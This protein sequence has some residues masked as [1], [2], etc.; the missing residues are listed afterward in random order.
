[1]PT[2]E[3][4]LHPPEWEAGHRDI[5]LLNTSKDLPDPP[6]FLDQEMMKILQPSFHDPELSQASEISH[7]VQLQRMESGMQ[8]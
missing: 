3:T 2:R 5:S 1:M 4:L 8:L 7:R 6:L